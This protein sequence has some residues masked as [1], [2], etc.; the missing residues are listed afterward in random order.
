[1]GWLENNGIVVQ[2]YAALT[3]YCE[4]CREKL[5]SDSGGITSSAIGDNWE[6]T[7]NENL[8]LVV[9][10]SFLAHFQE[11]MRGIFQ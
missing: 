3:A 10:P 1:M 4:H 2:G 5:C 7:A 6:S 8:V 9:S 11:V